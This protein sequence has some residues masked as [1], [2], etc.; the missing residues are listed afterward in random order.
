MN[1]SESFFFSLLPDEEYVSCKQLHRNLF[2]KENPTHA[3]AN[4]SAFYSSL[5]LF[6]VLIPQDLNELT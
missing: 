3:M 5:L 1:R 4:K 6:S 2:K